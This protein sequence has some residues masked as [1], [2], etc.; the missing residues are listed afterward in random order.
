MSEKNIGDQ[1][2]QNNNEK[3]EPKNE[4]VEDSE[5]Q[6]SDSMNTKNMFKLTSEKQL[7]IEKTDNSKEGNRNSLGDY[8]SFSTKEGRETPKYKY[9]KRHP[10]TTDEFLKMVKERDQL[11]L[12]LRNNS[13]NEVLRKEFT[14]L[15]NRTAALRRKLKLAYRTYLEE[16]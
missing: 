1:Q 8:D 13:S 3:I 15:R 6:T 11:H 12:R 10:W 16:L 7:S 4:Y 2:E 5:I 14:F 9:M